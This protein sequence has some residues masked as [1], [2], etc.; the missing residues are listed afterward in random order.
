MVSAAVK[1]L[2]HALRRANPR[3]QPNLYQY[4]FAV[5]IVV[6]GSTQRYEMELRRCRRR[7][8]LPSAA[9][10]E[11]LR[12]RLLRC[13]TGAPST[14]K[15]YAPWFAR[16]LGPAS[17]RLLQLED[18]IYGLAPAPLPTSMDHGIKLRFHP[19]VQVHTEVV[20]FDPGLVVLVFPAQRRLPQSGH[21]WSRIAARRESSS[22]YIKPRGRAIVQRARVG[23]ELFQHSPKTFAIS[24]QTLRFQRRS[25]LSRPPDV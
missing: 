10:P 3:H 7:C 15:L 11:T 22:D 4:P 25:S 9:P 16:G 17:S 20:I 21:D 19:G 13:G 14:L 5:S 23:R 18:V 2:W 12:R 8:A 24:K 1:R 6:Y